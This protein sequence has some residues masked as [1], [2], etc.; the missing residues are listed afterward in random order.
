MLLFLFAFFFAIVR[1]LFLST[2]ELYLRCLV[3]EKQ[4]QIANRT[5]EQHN[6]RPRMSVFDRFQFSLFAP[7]RRSLVG[8][9]ILSRPDTLMRWY[10]H[11]LKL[12]WIFPRKKPGRKAITKTIR[13]LVLTIKKLNPWFG[14][15]KIQGELAKNAIILGRTSIQRILH[16]FRRDGTLQ[17]W[18]SWAGFLKA[19][20]DS[21]FACDF[22]TVDT[23]FGKRFFVFFIQELKSRSIVQWGVTEFPTKSFIQQQIVAFKESRSGPVHLIHDHGPELMSFQYTAYGITNHPTC[24]ASPNLNAYAERFVGTIRRECLDRFIIV[25]QRQLRNLVKA[26]VEYYNSRRPHQGI[27][28]RLPDGSTPASEGAIRSRRVCFGLVHDFYRHVG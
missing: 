8:A 13:Q 4:L 5:L 22:L 18:G 15:S 3:L 16:G 23:A 12:R 2:G 19:H 6:L 20:W 28:N 21:L 14:L 24:I 7:F 17:P 1:F 27:G 26:Y 25:G 10:R 11:F 9:F